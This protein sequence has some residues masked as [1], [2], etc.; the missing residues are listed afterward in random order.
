[1]QT[2]TKVNLVGLYI[3]AHPFKSL[4]DIVVVAVAVFSVAVDAAEVYLKGGSVVIGTFKGLADAQDTRRAT[5]KRITV[6]ASPCVA[7]D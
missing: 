5:N 3:L 6:S 1:V 7:N 2:L 4:V